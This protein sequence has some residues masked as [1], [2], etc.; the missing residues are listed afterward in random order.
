MLPAIVKSVPKSSV[1]SSNLA[2][3][4]DA[5]AASPS[6]IVD[7]KYWWDD[8]LSSVCT[9][10]SYSQNPLKNINIIRDFSNRLNNHRLGNYQVLESATV[11]ECGE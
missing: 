10:N 9:N 6:P 8:E 3:N 7:N 2:S 1:S 4:F 5:I 11:E